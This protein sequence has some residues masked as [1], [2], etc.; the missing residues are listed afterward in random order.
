[1]P[2]VV[3]HDPPLPAG[4]IRNAIKHPDVQRGWWRRK[5]RAWRMRGRYCYRLVWNTRRLRW[6]LQRRKPNGDNRSCKHW[7]NWD[8]KPH[9]SADVAV[10]ASSECTYGKHS[11]V[12]WNC[13][14]AKAEVGADFNEIPELVDA[15]HNH[16][17]IPLD[18]AIQVL[19][20]YQN[21]RRI[22]RLKKE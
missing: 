16:L 4:I 9:L 5:T 21:V 20:K 15:V 11:E 8:T 22:N 14:Q 13:V 6:E 19:N 7:G 10:S 17:P 3:K 18:M 12:S 2:D 1:M